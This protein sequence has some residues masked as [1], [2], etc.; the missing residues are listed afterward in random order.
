MDGTV[1][2]DSNGDFVAQ[3]LWP[4]VSKLISYSCAMMT[5][6]LSRLGVTT[7]EHS[8]FFHS[9]DSIMELRND[10]ISYYPSTFMYDNVQGTVNDEESGANGD[11]DDSG[12]GPSSAGIEGK[13][14]IVRAVSSARKAKSLVG[15]WLAKIANSDPLP[16]DDSI[17]YDS[18]I[19]ERD[20]LVL[21]N[22]KVGSCASAANI[23]CNFCVLDIYEKYDNK[24]FMSKPKLPFKKWKKE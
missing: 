16:K 2:I 3:Q 21:V 11:P 14:K 10:Y 12:G 9:F 8:S 4:T 17:L 7:I 24:W 5:H 13:E 23:S 15:R 1:E 20:V 6:F 22:V 19:V 18:V